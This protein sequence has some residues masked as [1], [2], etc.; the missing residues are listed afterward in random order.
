[1]LARTARAIARDW[2]D[3][4]VAP[5]PGFRGALWHGSVR[6]LADDQPLDAASDL[7]L[8]LLFDTPPETFAGGKRLV[9]GALLDLTPLPWATLA[10]PAALLANHQLAP[11]FWAPEIICDP[12]GDLA[13]IRDAVTAGFTSR[14][15]V[16]RRVESAVDRVR[17]FLDG[18]DPAAP[19]AQSAMSWLFGTGVTTHVVLVAG[20]RN[21]TVRK[22]YLAARELLRSVDMPWVYDELLRLLGAEHID[23][24]TASR[25]LATLEPAF[26]AAGAAVRT[27]VAFPASDLSPEARPIAV[28]GS[29]AMVAGGDHRE[30]MFWIAVTWT[31]CMQVLATDAP[32]IAASHDAAFRAALADLGIHTVADMQARAG[33]VRECLPRLRDVAAAI[34]DATPDIEP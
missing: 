24:A 12:N 8:I 22:R 21:P 18:I 30:A 10:D 5:L 31:R 19:F 3:R 27:P 34:L 7:D 20:L 4:E 14:E 13:P 16:E 6:D 11:S 23:Q 2:I 28:D 1:M 32:G 26:D 9:D 15:W 17:I 25:H 29:R 33:A